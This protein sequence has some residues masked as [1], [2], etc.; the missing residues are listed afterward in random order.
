MLGSN[1]L[2]NKVL[3]SKDFDIIRRN[4]LDAKHF[5]GYEQEYEFI[6]NHYKKFGNVPDQIVFLESFPKFDLTPVSETEDFLVS[7]V[8]EEYGYVKFNEMLPVLTQKISEDSRDAYE[9]LKQKMDSGELRPRVVCN[10]IDIVE[11]AIERYEKYLDKQKLET[12][13]TISSGMPELDEILGGWE[14]GEELVTIVGRVNQGKSWILL[15]FMVEAWK[16]GKRVGIYSGE[17][18]HIKLGYRFDALFQHFSNRALVRGHHVDGYK[19]YIDSLPGMPGCF[20]IV[21]KEHFG[22][23][24]TVQQIRNFVEE[25]KLDIVGIDQLSLMADGRA[26]RGEPLRIRMGHITEDLFLLSSEYKIPILAL[27]QANRAATDKD[28]DD[29]P[30]LENIKE[31]DDIAANSSKCIGMRQANGSLIL[32]IIKNRE[33]AVGSKLRYEWDI[34]KAHMRYIPTN[35][36]AA[37]EETREM[38]IAANVTK[39]DS[40]TSAFPF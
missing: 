30:G 32:D 5:P 26:G 24:P 29:A 12:S 16:Q 39:Y 33:G 6:V 9:F 11:N 25:N 23:A 31:S 34:D 4:G 21:T 2:I 18:S 3:Q 27:A 22:G 19:E 13:A 17:M 15:K 10:G 28:S 40:Q 38:A 8:Y 14:F 20:K 36:D 7:K 1:L 35:G 37:K